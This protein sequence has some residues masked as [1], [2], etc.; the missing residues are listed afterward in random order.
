MSVNIASPVKTF[1]LVHGAWYGR[2]CWY[3]LIPLLE[4][5][6]YQVIAINLPGYGEDNTEPS[7][8]RLDDYVKK[9]VEAT[10]TVAGK[11]VMVGHSMGGAVISQASEILGP[12]KVEKLVFLDAFLLKNGE[13][14][15]DQVE[16]MNAATKLETDF[17][18]EQPASDYLI[19]SEDKKTCVVN[20][21]MIAEVFSHDCSAEDIALATKML[22]WQPVA[23][24]ATALQVTDARYGSI[25][26]YFIRCTLAKDLDRRSIVQ[27]MPCEKVVEL[28]SS[29]SVFLSM[30]GR[31]AQVLEEIY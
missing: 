2:W 22:R 4:Q 6:G 20:P 28:P 1:L 29:H 30:P 31:L 24:L 17:I 14:I 26:K 12:G 5:K 3:K 23:C 8:I 9:V 16:K 15:F 25:P 21:E 11:L 10:E 18:I 13:S 27:N 19:F 7:G